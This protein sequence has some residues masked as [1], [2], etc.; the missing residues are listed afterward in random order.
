LSEKELASILSNSRVMPLLYKESPDMP[1]SAMEGLSS[2]CAIICT[3]KMGLSD[4]IKKDNSGVVVKNISD[5]DKALKLIFSS[6]RY[7]KNA[8]ISAEKH[9]SIR[10]IESYRNI[11]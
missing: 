3:E 6:T 9:F 8:R 11:L 7:N 2:G 10:N 4:L 5:F 1:L